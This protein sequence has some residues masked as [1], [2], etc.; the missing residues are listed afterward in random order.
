MGGVDG[1]KYLNVKQ[2]QLKWDEFPCSFDELL[3]AIS[4][5]P[6]VSAMGESMWNVLQAV[7]HLGNIEFEGSGEDDAVFKSKSEGMACSRLALVAW[8]PRKAL[9]PGCLCLQFKRQGRF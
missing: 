6:L 4:V 3:K 8:T 9:Q 5:I 2:S 1:F 7:L